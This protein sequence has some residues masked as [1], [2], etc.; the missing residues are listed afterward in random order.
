MNS[1]Q[2]LTGQPKVK[3]AQRPFDLYDGRAAGFEAI[4]AN[5]QRFADSRAK[6]QAVEAGFW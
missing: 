3:H 6:K 4:H 2:K 1:K 5:P